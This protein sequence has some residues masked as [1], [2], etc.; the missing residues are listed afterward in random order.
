V[1]SRF[2]YWNAGIFVWRRDAL[3]ATLGQ[4]APDV[5]H[6]IRD[7]LRSVTPDGRPGWPGSALAA[8]YEALRATSIDYALLEPASLEGRVAV[9]PAAIGWSDLGSWS[10]IREQRSIDGHPVITAESPA[11]VIEVETR[12]VLVHAAGGRLVA[13][14]GL[15]DVIVVDT[16]DALLVTSAESAQEVRKVVERLREAGRHDLL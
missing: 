12:N 8:T 2:A 3:L 15:E 10:A 7:W 6:P 1:A 11:E 16:P 5:S 9:V 14:V 13:V 4:H